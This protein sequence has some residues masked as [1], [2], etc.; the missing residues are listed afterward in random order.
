MNGAASA[1]VSVVLLGAVLLALSSQAPSVGDSARADGS[2]S[3]R[4][5][6]RD[7]SPVRLPPPP[8]EATGSAPQTSANTAPPLR[9]E[10]LAL[11]TAEPTAEPSPV[12]GRTLLRLLEHGQGPQIELAWPAD[13]VA[14]ANLFRHLTACHGMR[15]ALLRHDGAIF[16][17]DGPRDLAR[18]IDRD[19]YSGYAR[20]P[21]GA[22]A[23]DERALIARIRGRHDLGLD[24]SPIRIF[25]RRFDADLLSGLRALIGP[26][27]ANSRK[28]HGRYVLGASG[29]SVRGIVADGRAVAGIISLRTGNRSC[30]R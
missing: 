2:P 26:G 22:L 27:Y 25:P 18:Q 30:G 12:P 16:L 15:V 23:D 9:A 17:A 4:E 13:A 10:P 11:E 21:A 1:G 5:A 7:F 24:T 28:L 20:A 6:G 3:T 8:K 19:L 29:L 14:R